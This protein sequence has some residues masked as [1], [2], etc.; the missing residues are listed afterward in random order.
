MINDPVFPLE[1]Y[2][3]EI[4]VPRRAIIQPGARGLDCDQPATF[5]S[6]EAKISRLAS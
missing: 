6:K 5:L 4:V 1:E 2:G 3:Y